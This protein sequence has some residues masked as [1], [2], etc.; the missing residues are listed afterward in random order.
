M[1][2][3]R[4]S[5][6]FG[7]I[8]LVIFSLNLQARL[9]E[10]HIR[11]ADR[12]KMRTGE[13]LMETMQLIDIKGHPSAPEIPT[14]GQIRKGISD[15]LNLDRSWK[16][17]MIKYVYVTEGKV[18][19]LKPYIENI[20]RKERAAFFD[21]LAQ[22]SYQGYPVL[23]I[24]KR[25]TTEEIKLRTSYIDPNEGDQ[26]LIIPQWMFDEDSMIGETDRDLITTLQQN[27]R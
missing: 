2:F 9:F 25:P 27:I 7:F 3:I 24:A 10:V 11:D 23:L 12:F 18:Y 19:N 14:Y 6:F 13:T 15:A 22:N 16:N 21:D 4:K 20:G 26:D 5:I 1:N 8:F 17:F